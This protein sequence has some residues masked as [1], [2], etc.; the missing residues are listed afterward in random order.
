M[1]HVRTLALCSL[2]LALVPITGCELILDFDRSKIP[3]DAG[4]DAGVAHDAAVRDAAVNDDAGDEDA[5]TEAER[6]Q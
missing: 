3:V 6:D 5:A 1:H 4:A 2:W